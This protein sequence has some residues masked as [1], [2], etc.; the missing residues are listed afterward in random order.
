MLR[1]QH[2]VLCA[3][4]VAQWINVLVSTFRIS[5][6]FWSDSLCSLL[7]RQTSCTKC[8]RRRWLQLGELTVLGS[9]THCKCQNADFHKI[10]DPWNI[11]LFY[12]WYPLLPPRKTPT[13]LPLPTHIPC[14]YWLL[15]LTITIY[16][17]HSNGKLN[18]WLVIDYWWIYRGWRLD[19][20]VDTI[21]KPD[22]LMMMWL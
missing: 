5:A 9:N 4:C 1:H 8:Q 18:N 22:Q 17:I 16:F 3:D 12:F 2:K 10:N 7:T 6:C 20:L 13:Y 15:L 21:C 11:S 14:S 19:M